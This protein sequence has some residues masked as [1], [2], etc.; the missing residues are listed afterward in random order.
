LVI[1]GAII[2]GMS[3][4]GSVAIGTLYID[5]NAGPFGALFVP[6]I[7]PFIVAG[8]ADLAGSGLLGSAESNYV[9]VGLIQAGSGAMLLAGIFAKKTYL[10]REGVAHVVRPEFFVGPGSV[11]M[12]VT[13]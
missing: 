1:P 3:Y 12:K 4:F 6:V 5:S 2:F 10:V 7:G 8:A 11:G 9:L 13:F